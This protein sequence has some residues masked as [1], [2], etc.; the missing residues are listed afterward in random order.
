MESKETDYAV[1]CA[2]SATSSGTDSDDQ[3][4]DRLKSIGRGRGSFPLFITKNY[5]ETLKGTLTP[6]SG[7]TEDGEY[8]VMDIIESFDGMCILYFMGD[9]DFGHTFERQNQHL[10]ALQNLHRKFGNM[11][12][13][14]AVRICCVTNNIQSDTVRETLKV[15][16]QELEGVVYGRAR[17]EILRLYGLMHYDTGFFKYGLMML[18]KECNVLVHPAECMDS[19]NDDNLGVFEKVATLLIAAAK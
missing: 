1:K 18:D 8:E 2:E 19:K 13:I 7:N 14:I 16:G 4:S 11:V 15:D 10:K 3:K 9:I 17:M 5:V 12:H 6:K